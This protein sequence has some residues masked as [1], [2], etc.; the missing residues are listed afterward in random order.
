[1]KSLVKRKMNNYESIQARLFRRDLI[2]ARQ[3]RKLPSRDTLIR[4]I[5]EYIKKFKRS[6]KEEVVSVL[7]DILETR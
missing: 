1:M 4:R 6:K 5:N 7:E 2:R 3:P